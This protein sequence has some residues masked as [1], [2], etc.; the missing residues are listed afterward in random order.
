MLLFFVFSASQHRKH[1]QRT[2]KVD[3]LLRHSKSQIFLVENLVRNSFFG[4]ALLCP[5]PLTHF[6][7]YA[8][9]YI[10]LF[11]S[12]GPFL[13]FSHK[14][15]QPCF[16]T[17]FFPLIYFFYS[18]EAFCNCSQ[19]SYSCTE[20]WHYSPKQKVVNNIHF[21]ILQPLLQL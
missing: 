10:I 9:L 1:W 4:F 14:K 2:S 20:F 8:P 3:G 13:S 15:F 16:Q 18:H 6:P 21:Q 5:L 12:G 19:K 11:L 7:A 17:F